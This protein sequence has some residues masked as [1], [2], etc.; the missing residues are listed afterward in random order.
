[1]YMYFIVY[2]VYITIIIYIIFFYVYIGLVSIMS[3][4]LELKVT[5]G[6]S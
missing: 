1:M 4:P 3:M 6:Q 2:N 5:I